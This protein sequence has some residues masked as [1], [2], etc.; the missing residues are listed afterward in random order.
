MAFNFNFVTSF[1][2]SAILGA[3]LDQLSTSPTVAYSLRK[4]RSAYTDNAIRVRRSLDNAEQDIG[5]VNNDLN[6]T[7]LL[8]FVGAGNGFVT[9]WYDQSGNNRNATQS[10]ALNQPRIVTDGVVQTRN[11]RPTIVFDGAGQHLANPNAALMRNVSGASLNVVGNRDSDVVAEVGFVGVGINTGG[12]RSLIS[13][14]NPIAGNTGLAAGGRRL[15]TDPFQAIGTGAYSSSLLVVTSRT[16]YSV[17]KLDLFVNG[18]NQGTT[19]TFQTAGVT[20]NDAGNLGVGSNH[21]GGGAYLN[22]GISEVMIF[23]SALSTTD[24]QLLERN[25]GSH[26][27]ITVA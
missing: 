2:F 5:F 11:G 7:E 13:F 6:T 8:A 17:R 24:R 9:T 10:T 16:D 22:G 20:E 21:N 27:N 25:Q 18:A 12:N 15:G 14:R 19:S 4:M 3:I 1:A 23:N 26:Y